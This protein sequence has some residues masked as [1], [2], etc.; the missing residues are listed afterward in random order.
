MIDWSPHITRDRDIFYLLIVPSNVHHHQY[1]GRFFFSWLFTISSFLQMFD[2]LTWLYERSIHTHQKYNNN[3]N[4]N[5]VQKRTKKEKR[6]T[7]KSKSFKRKAV[8]MLDFMR[9]SLLCSWHNSQQLEVDKVAP[10]N[11]NN[12][13]LTANIGRSPRRQ[14][15]SKWSNVSH[16]C[17]AP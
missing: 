10:S 12:N 1:C 6:K 5:S 2:Q 7:R 9:V 17:S 16:S 15:C 4:N 13:S 11:N 8:E 14:L 3:N